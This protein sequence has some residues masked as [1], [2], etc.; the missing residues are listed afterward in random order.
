MKPDPTKPHKY[1]TYLNERTMSA[2]RGDEALSG[3]LNQ[4]VDRYLFTVSASVARVHGLFSN[5]EWRTLLDAYDRKPDDL[6][7]ADE[8]FRWWS[9]GSHG[10]CG[11]ALWRAAKLPPDDFVALMELL[12]AELLTGV[13]M[14][15]SVDT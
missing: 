1:T 6:L 4:I 13:A 8:V 9:T 5:D 2:M 7:A 11:E 3:R 10:I 15:N 14:T 12:E